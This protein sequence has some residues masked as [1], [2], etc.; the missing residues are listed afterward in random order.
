MPPASLLGVTVTYPSPT[1][2][3]R[4]M[5][6]HSFFHAAPHLS[7]P[8]LHFDRDMVLRTTWP[9]YTGRFIVTLR[10]VSTTRRSP[11]TR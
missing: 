10:C 1:S 9:A 2:P 8:P 3:E 7:K 5:V 4:E 11:S 6:Y